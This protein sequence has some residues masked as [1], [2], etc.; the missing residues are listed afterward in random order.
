M[1]GALSE[2]ERFVFRNIWKAGV[3]AKVLAFVWKALLDR[4]PTRHNLEIRHCFPPDIGSSCVWCLSLPECTS[5]IFLHCNMARRI[6]INLIGWLDLNFI[7]P[8][9]LVIHRECWSSGVMKKK[10]RKGLRMIRQAAIWVIWK[11]RNECIFN[12]VVTRCDEVVE[13]I[14][15]LSWKWAFGKN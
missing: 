3:P 12:D 13:D 4:I 8:P 15:L 11:A 7:M 2:G 9:N 5:H 10:I 1:E 6:W 14:K